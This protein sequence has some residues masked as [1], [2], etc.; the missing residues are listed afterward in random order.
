MIG[1]DCG[2]YNLVACQRDKAGKFAHK[3]EVNAF[4]QVP[5][6]KENRF[7]FNMMKKSGVPLIEKGE[8]AYA[9]GE[10]AV[11]MAYTMSGTELKRPMSDGCV[12]PKEKDAFQIMS[13]MMHS[14]LGDVEK[15]DD[16]L[17]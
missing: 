15:A 1:F 9:L 10:S 3:R 6:G 12:N 2:T 17:Y 16:V 11:T 8:V 5:C 14:L 13:I 7:V 4:I